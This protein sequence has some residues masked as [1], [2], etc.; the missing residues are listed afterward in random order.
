M[1]QVP[2]FIQLV[3]IVYLDG[4]VMLTNRNQGV[5]GET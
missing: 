1:Y 5:T 3:F 4:T 2:S